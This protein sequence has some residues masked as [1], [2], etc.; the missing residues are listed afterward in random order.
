PYTVRLRVHNHV[1]SCRGG[2]A[3]HPLIQRHTADTGAIQIEV[4]DT[5]AA[6]REMFAAPA[7]QRRDVGNATVGEAR[8]GWWE[9]M[10]DAPWMPHRPD[11]DD[12]LGYALMLNI[13]PPSMDA[14]EAIGHL[15][16]FDEAGSLAACADALVRAFD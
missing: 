2:Y 11:P 8:R 9:P 6:Q 12:P 5:L 10:R 7:E 16:R 15:D 3:M 13:A 1:I 14:A 4:I